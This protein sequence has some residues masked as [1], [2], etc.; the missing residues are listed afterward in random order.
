MHQCRDKN[1]F[2][3]ATRDDY[4]PTGAR[5]SP[6]G[7]CQHA[8]R[9]VIIHSEIQGP[10][11]PKC[12]H[13]PNHVDRSHPDVCCSTAT[14]PRHHSQR[15]R[16]AFRTHRRVPD[17]CTDAC[18]HHSKWNDPIHVLLFLPVFLPRHDTYVGRV[19]GRD[20]WTAMYGLAHY[21]VGKWECRSNRPSNVPIAIGMLDRS[22]DAG[23]LVALCG[24][25]FF[26]GK[27]L[28]Q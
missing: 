14:T 21:L 22:H 8:G 13:R 16:S 10:I 1:Y 7:W 15:E 9:S 18:C 26:L 5:T 12:S 11:F 27:D 3:S 28:F 17:P 4:R 6:R 20:L 25:G 19:E 23:H 2:Y 24:C